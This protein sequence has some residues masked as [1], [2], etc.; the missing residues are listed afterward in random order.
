MTLASCLLFSHSSLPFSSDHPRVQIVNLSTNRFSGAIQD[1]FSTD[2]SLV[3]LSLE[4]YAFTGVIPS[5]F[6]NIAGLEKLLLQANLFVGTVPDAICN[7][8]GFDDGFRFG[9]QELVAD[10]I[11]F[12]GDTDVKCSCCTICCDISFVTPCGSVDTTS[13]PETESDVICVQDFLWDSDSG[14]VTP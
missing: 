2:S 8:R 12:R 9:L 11:P 10:C 6:A 1:A 13:L 3:E 7:L 4:S 14:V 5:T